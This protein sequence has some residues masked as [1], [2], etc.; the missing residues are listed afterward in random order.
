MRIRL[1]GDPILR[2]KAKKIE[3]IDESLREI[4][5]EMVG[6]MYSGDG[7]G[8]AAPQVGLSI[9]LIVVDIGD[10]WDAYINPEIIE[11][12]DEIIVGEEGCLSIP[13]VFEE[14]PR[15]RWIKIKYQDFNGNYH[16]ELKEDYAARVFAHEIDHLEG[17]LFIDYLSLAKRR[18]L[19][20]KLNE[21][22]RR[23]KVVSK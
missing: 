6:I 16:E 17:K 22:R 21:I 7:V 14:V 15:P 23:S 1:L 2:Q 4:A 8:L 5:K 20:P 13:E 9:R 12:S 11:K 3:I 10:G 19:M 18:L